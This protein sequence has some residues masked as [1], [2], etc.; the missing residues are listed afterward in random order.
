MIGTG[1]T[2]FRQVT[3]VM[4]H[5]WASN[6]GPCDIRCDLVSAEVHTDMLGAFKMFVEVSQGLPK[7]SLELIIYAPYPV[8]VARLPFVVR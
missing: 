2:P 6:V 4:G 5:L 7:G 8:E 1:F 3:I